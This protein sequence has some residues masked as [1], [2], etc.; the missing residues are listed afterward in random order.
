MYRFQNPRYFFPSQVCIKMSRWVL[1]DDSDS[2][3]I[4]AGP[5]FADLGSQDSFGNFGP[6]YL[7]TLHGINAPGSFSY[8]FSGSRV[9]ITSTV[10]FPTIGNVTNPSWQC[11]VDG[12]LLGSILYQTGN[13]RLRLC[14]KDGLDDGPHTITVKV[15]VSEGHTFWLDYIQYLP[16]PDTPLDAAALSIDTTDPGV[17]LG[18]QGSWTQKF[19][20][21][22]TQ[23][24]DASFRFQFNGITVEWLGF[25][26]N[27]LPMAATTGTY[28]IDGQPPVSFNLNGT[29][30]K[31]TG[32]QF[33]QVFFQ[34]SL[35]EGK[36][37]TIEVSYQGDA[38]KTPLSLSVLQVQ[39]GAN[40]LSSSTTSSLQSSTSSFISSTSGTVTATSSS[41]NKS[42]ST[43]A[44]AIIGG[45]LGGVATILVICALVLIIVGRRRRTDSNHDGAAS[46]SRPPTSTVPAGSPSRPLYRVIPPMKNAVVRRGYTGPEGSM[47]ASPS[48][49]SPTLPLYSSIGGGD[50]S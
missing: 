6:P 46:S 40:I 5:W 42:G 9:L 4:Y 25:Y 1:V 48:L 20:G 29:A 38:T 41:Q 12:E 11:V 15:D 30:A 28:S 2:S 22:F 17:I 14:E 10:Q 39:H 24:S 7:S 21:Y 44:G 45:T 3:I 31:D 16:F 49:L 37:H 19:P 34:T 13:N 18:L 26:D 47:S 36:N 8:T 43:H 32:M 27:S 50:K 35:L 23:R 33:N